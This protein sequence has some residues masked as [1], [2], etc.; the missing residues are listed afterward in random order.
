M[1]DSKAVGRWRRWPAVMRMTP[2]SARPSSAPR[3]GSR[4]RY[5]RRSRRRTGSCPS[6][7]GRALLHDL[8]GL[9][10]ASGD[11]QAAGLLLDRLATGP[12]ARMPARPARRGAA[13]P[14][15]GARP[16]RREDDSRGAHDTSAVTGAMLDS[17]LRRA[18]AT[19]A[20][21]RA[22]LAQSR[23]GHRPDGTGRVR[24]RPGGSW[25]R[26]WCPASRS[27]SSSRRSGPS[28]RS[29][30]PDVAAILLGRWP[31]LS[32]ALR[33]EVIA[34]LLS[35]PA[36]RMALLDAVEAGVVPAALIPPSR[37][38]LLMADRDADDPGTRS[39]PARRGRARPA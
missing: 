27:K 28:P 21:G 4:D 7:G 20:D 32:P 37:R 19:A 18:E 29:P 17:V 10:G 39:F 12:I 1:S 35:R 25:D 13:G 31:A 6:A 36:W 34:R 9:V 11:L 16:C 26:C 15:R 2:G 22:D 14:R 3:G 33:S 8:A 24:R 23:A 38:D 5:S 30:I